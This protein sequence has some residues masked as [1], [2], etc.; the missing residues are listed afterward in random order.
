MKRGILL[1]SIT[2]VL[3]TGL[4]LFTGCESDIV[5]PGNGPHPDMIWDFVNSSIM[6]VVTDAEGNNLLDKDVEGNIL[7]N[8][9]TVKYRN[10]KYTLEKPRRTEPD[11]ED[12]EDSGEETGYETGKPQTR[13]NMPR[14]LGLRLCRYT[15]GV[16]F[17][18][19]GEFSP[20][21]H[22]TNE[23]FTIEWGDGTKDVISFDL[24]ITWANYDPT[25]HRKLVLNGNVCDN[26]LIELVKKGNK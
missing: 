5:P 17:L 26:G 15:D 7:D 3:F 4:A 24:Y 20:Q 10:K 2:L 18:E 13:Y 22:Y 21:S 12:G 25:V 9:I 8:A 23:T 14:E 1:L 16:Q 19:F 6:F 11:E